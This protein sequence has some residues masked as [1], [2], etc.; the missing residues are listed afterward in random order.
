MK[1]KVELTLDIKPEF[2]KQ[3]SPPVDWDWH[4]LLDVS[5]EVELKDVIVTENGVDN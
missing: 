1:Y 3:S 5:E 2:L 4:T